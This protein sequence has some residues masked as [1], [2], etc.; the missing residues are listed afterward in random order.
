MVRLSSGVA[1]FCAALTCTS[2]AK[3]DNDTTLTAYY[4]FGINDTVFVITNNSTQTDTAITLRTSLGSTTV[5]LD[6]L[7][8]G[9]TEY[10]AFNQPNG[11]FIIDP[12]SKGLS[13]ATQYQ[14]SVDV[15]D[16]VLTSSWFSPGS[17]L[18]GSY[19]DFLGNTCFGIAAGCGVA[20]TGEVAAVPEPAS[21]ALLG[22]PLPLLGLVAARRRRG[23]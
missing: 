22:L 14:F 11:G 15:G 18:S 16:T 8:A 6:D 20:L 7:L 9:A 10:F 17:N 13:D 21:L 1:L 23:A 2:T 3:A 4:D 19:V 5:T 12:A